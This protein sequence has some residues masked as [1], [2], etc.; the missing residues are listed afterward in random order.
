MIFTID[1]FISTLF[2]FK[3][4]LAEAASQSRNN[5]GNIHHLRPI[6]REMSLTY[7]KLLSKI[8]LSEKVQKY[9]E[10]W[11]DFER[12]MFSETVVCE[13]PGIVRI[14]CETLC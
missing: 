9:P 2:S 3:T 11:H 7:V 1:V 6:L 10:L 13:Y 4:L 14:Y 5:T 8:S 12:T